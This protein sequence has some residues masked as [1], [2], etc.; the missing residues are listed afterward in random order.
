MAPS[1]DLRFTN[2]LCL[3]TV[4][5]F[6]HFT[7]P[8]GQHYSSIGYE[9]TNTQCRSFVKKNHPHSLRLLS[10]RGEHAGLSQSLLCILAERGDSGAGCVS[11][12]CVS[13]DNNGMLPL[14]PS[15]SGGSPGSGGDA[16]GGGGGDGDDGVVSASP[17][18]RASHS[19]SV[20]PT[21]TTTG[22]PPRTEPVSSS[23]CKATP[24][25]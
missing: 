1:F 14:T 5:T 10:E 4:C 6:V 2:R 24:A 16:C 8:N 9:S 11:S 19:L 12:R 21:T 7:N 13:D 15:S 18:L 25:P 3:H 17:R 20:S 23:N 22:T